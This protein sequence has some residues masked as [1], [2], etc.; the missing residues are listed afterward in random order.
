[1]FQAEKVGG[2][3]VLIGS[4]AALLRQLEDLNSHTWRSD[5]GL[6]G[7]WRREGSEHG[8]PLEAGARLAF[9]ILRDL[10]DKS[11]ANR[12]PMLLDY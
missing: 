10:A 7:T 6:L 4:S 11:V 9:A 1:V 12:L 2:G 8:A 5:F 3:P